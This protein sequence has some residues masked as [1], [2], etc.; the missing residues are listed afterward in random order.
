MNKYFG[1][2]ASSN[3]QDPVRIEANDRRYFVPVYSKHKVNADETKRF[4]LR[5]TDWLE[6]KVCKN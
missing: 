5:F 4:F 1:I 3:V 2:V 6:R